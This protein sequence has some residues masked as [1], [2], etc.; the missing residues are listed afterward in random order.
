MDERHGS[1]FF[2]SQ[3]WM[4]RMIAISVILLQNPRFVLPKEG[5]FVDGGFFDC[6]LRQ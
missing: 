1:L 2:F 4:L 5:H 3:E 6:I